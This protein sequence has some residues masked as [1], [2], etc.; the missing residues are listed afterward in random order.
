M[1]DEGEGYPRILTDVEQ[2]YAVH[3]L[4]LAKC[5]ATLWNKGADAGRTHFLAIQKELERLYGYKYAPLHGESSE[6]SGS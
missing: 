6:S 5:Q 2:A 1:F 3:L 4:E